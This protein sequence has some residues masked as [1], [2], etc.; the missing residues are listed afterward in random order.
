MIDKC[1][2]KV[3]SPI[4][5]LGYKASSAAHRPSVLRA[6]RNVANK[7]APCRT[8]SAAAAVRDGNRPRGACNV[9]PPLK[10][11]G[12]ARGQRGVGFG[13]N[14]VFARRERCDS[15]PMRPSNGTNRPGCSGIC[16]RHPNDAV[17]ANARPDFLEVC[18][19]F[20]IAGIV[21]PRGNYRPGKGAAG[22][23]N[24]C[25]RGETNVSA[26]LALRKKAS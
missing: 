6:A 10:T 17:C 2:A 23:T 7:P 18:L 12:D 8:E 25:L 13:V 3:A 4:A 15:V 11:L 9:G 26:Y 14:A 24:Y 1:A 22:E 16:G 20:R 5:M 21:T 19:K